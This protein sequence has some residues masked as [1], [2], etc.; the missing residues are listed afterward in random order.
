MKKQLCSL[1][2]QRGKRKP[3]CYRK[4][5]GSSIMVPEAYDN[6]WQS[7]NPLSFGV[8][9]EGVTPLAVS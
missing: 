4:I 5:N 8:S 7:V 3:G 2:A 1:M 6:D 9:L